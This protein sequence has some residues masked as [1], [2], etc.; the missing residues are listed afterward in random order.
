MAV[1]FASLEYLAHCIPFWGTMQLSYTQTEVAKF[2]GW[3][4][5]LCGALSE[6]L[7]K[8]ENQI[9]TAYSEGAV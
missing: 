9:G 8:V 7:V 1:N 5:I 6:S 3:I 2:A 4:V